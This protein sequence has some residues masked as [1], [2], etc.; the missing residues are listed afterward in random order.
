MV[1]VDETLRHQ[2]VRLAEVD[3]ADVTVGAVAS[4]AAASGFW[5][6]LVRVHGDAA[7]GSFN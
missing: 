1:N 5:V 4:D 6:P 2:P 7:G 3:A